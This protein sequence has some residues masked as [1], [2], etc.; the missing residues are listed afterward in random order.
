MEYHFILEQLEYPIELQ[1]VICIKNAAKRP[2]FTT[3]TST[4]SV[5]NTQLNKSQHILNLIKE[6]IN[7]Q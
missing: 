5:I 1:A 6:N 7:C 3:L 2:S 4:E